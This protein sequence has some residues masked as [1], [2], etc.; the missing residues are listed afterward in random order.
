MSEVLFEPAQARQLIDLLATDDAFRE[1]FAADPLAALISSRIL[2]A[3]ADPKVR[4]VI[5]ACC[6][7]SALA[8]KETILAA[9]TE[10]D[11]MLTSRSSQT[12]PA[13]DANLEGGRTLK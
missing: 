6:N 10:L 1:Q 8:S 13:L 2:A 12:V 9:R 3:D 7:V 11:R 4:A 5:A